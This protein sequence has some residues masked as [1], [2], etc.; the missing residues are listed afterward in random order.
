MDL[1]WK[2]LNV[3]IRDIRKH[4]SL[5]MRVAGLDKRHVKVLEQTILAGDD[6]PAIKVAKVGKALYVVDGYHRLE[7]ADLAGSSLIW[8]EVASMSLSEAKDFALLANTRH[9]KNLKPGDKARIFDTFVQRGKHLDA[10]G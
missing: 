1:N 3:P 8:A 5:Q 2:L 9:G 4:E 7:A 6:F 10:K